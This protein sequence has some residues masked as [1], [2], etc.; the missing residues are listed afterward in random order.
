MTEPSQAYTVFPLTRP[1][2]DIAKDQ[3]CTGKDGKYTCKG[4]C[5]PGTESCTL[6]S[7]GSRTAGTHPTTEICNGKDDDCDA[8][9]DNGVTASACPLTQGVCAGKARTCSGGG[10]TACNAQTYGSDYETTETKCDDKDNDCDGRVD[11]GATCKANHGCRCGRCFPTC[12]SD[13]DCPAGGPSQLRCVN[14]A[15]AVPRSGASCPRGEPCRGG[16]CVPQPGS[17]Q[18][19]CQLPATCVN[20]KCQ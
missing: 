18:P 3:G 1:W 9:D 13:S 19:P 16:M 12:T 14:G 10:W 17:C 11:N 5:A 4:T 7:W 6:G 8:T 15:C 2:Y 20:G